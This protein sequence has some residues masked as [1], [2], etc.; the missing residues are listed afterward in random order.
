MWN[1]AN[2]INMYPSQTL[3][4]G[5][6]PYGTNY[7]RYEIIRV[8]GENGA[9]AFQMAPN[10]NILLLDENDPIIWLAQ[11]DGAGYKTVTPYQ[12]TPYQPDPVIDPQTE[13]TL[14]MLND[15]DQRIKELEEKVNA[16]SNTYNVKSNTN[17]NKQN[18]NSR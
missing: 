2:N 16:K 18:S 12:I 14:K 8:N 3:A 9:K 10:S 1:N 6:N 15:M 11:T 5:Y 17:T 7:S 13:Q 4:N